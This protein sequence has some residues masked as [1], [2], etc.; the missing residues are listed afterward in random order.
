LFFRSGWHISISLADVSSAGWK[1]RFG[2]QR[3]GM[4]HRMG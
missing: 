4:S 2:P 3:F 1:A